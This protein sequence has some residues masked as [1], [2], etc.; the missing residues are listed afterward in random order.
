MARAIADIERDIKELSA[1]ERAEL[2][3]SLIADLDAPAETDV[4][5]AWLREAE[6]RLA[7]IESGTAE[8]VPG[9]KVLNEAR[10]RLK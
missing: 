4:E 1:R 9:P 7:E 3:R 8:T 6:R 2:L 10:S 5:Q